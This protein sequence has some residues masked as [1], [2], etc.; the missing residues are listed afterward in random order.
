MTFSNPVVG[1]TTLIRPAIHSPDYVPGVSGWSINKDGTAEFNDVVIRGDLE[2]DNYVPGVSGWKLDKNGQA[3]FHNVIIRGGGTDVPIAIGAST[4]SQVLIGT[5]ADV[6]YIQFPTNQAIEKDPTTLVAGPFASGQPFEQAS[7][8]I[9]GPNVDGATDKAT[10]RLWSEANDGSIPASFYWETG[11]GFAE[12]RQD[13]WLISRPWVSI[14]PSA[15]ANDALTVSPDS[16]HTGNL[17]VLGVGG[18]TKASVDKN[19]N[20]TANNIQT[21]TATVN[22]VAVTQV[23]ATVTFPHAF[24]TIPVVVCSRQ[25]SPANAG[26]VSVSATSITT[27]GFTMRFNTGDA[28]AVNITGLVGGYIAMAS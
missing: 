25:N 13:R 14:T 3:E 15:T 7:F 8:Q 24:D 18:T 5:T 21:G 1:G 27:T 23:D 22:F 2:S 9:K 16:G 10:V 19:G 20:L 11:L 26:K 4:D 12:F 28:T 17:L 6:G